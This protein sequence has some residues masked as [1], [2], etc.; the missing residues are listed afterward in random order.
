[1]TGSGGEGRTGEELEIYENVSKQFTK[2]YKMD[3]Q[4]KNFF[5]ELSQKFPKKK[6][7]FFGE[8]AMEISKQKKS[9]FCVRKV[10]HDF[11]LRISLEIFVFFLFV[12]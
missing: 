2:N 7:N 10:N 1:M 6:R 11:F 5:E 8:F 9:F 12:L 3:K 4:K